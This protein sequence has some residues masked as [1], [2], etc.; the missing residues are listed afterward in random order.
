MVT[1]IVDFDKTFIKEHLLI[2]MI[3]FTVF[4]SP[5]HFLSRLRF[6]IRAALCG[7]LSPVLSRFRSTNDMGVK[8]AYSSLRGISESMILEFVDRRKRNGYWINVNEH[9]I[10]ILNEIDKFPKIWEAGIPSL[11]VSSQGSPR[12]AIEW[13]MNRVDVKERIADLSN[14]KSLIP[15][16]TCNA[17][18]MEFRNGIATGRLV[19]PIIS[20]TQRLQQVMKST[21]PCIFIGD[22]EDER[23]IKQNITPNVCFLNVNK[24]KI[25]SVV[26]ILSSWASRQIREV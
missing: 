9:T 5:M 3:L 20:K 8:I 25:S 10:K 1:I 12:I 6:F 24:V 14:Y 18:I 2:Q 21:D 13:F 19:A 17:N 7:L 23:A 11:I 22:S 4:F 16:L 15:S 26:S